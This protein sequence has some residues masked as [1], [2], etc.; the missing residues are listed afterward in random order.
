MKVPL[1]VLS[2]ISA[3]FK[4]FRSNELELKEIV[5]ET[6]KG[7]IQITTLVDQPELPLMHG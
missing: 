5:K 2:K 3:N 6:S 4:T 1:L 7:T